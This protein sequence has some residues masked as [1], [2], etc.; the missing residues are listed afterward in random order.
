MCT[1][2]KDSFGNASSAYGLGREARLALEGARAKVATCI[3]ARADEIVFTSGGT[4]SDNLAIRGVAR[5]LAGHGNHIVTTAIEHHAVLHTCQSLE[6]E[7][8]EVTYVPVGSQGAVD[9][10]D[11][12][13][14]IRTDTILISIMHANNE[15][16]AIQPVAEVSAIAAGAGAVLHTDAVQ[17]LGK[18]PVDVGAMPADLISISGHKIYGPKG[19][20]ALYVK[21]DTQVLP[22]LTGG[23]HENG[24]RAGTEN[25]AGALALA[26]AMEIAVGYQEEEADRLAGLRERLERRVLESVDGVAVHGA[27]AARVSNTSNMSF[28]SVDGE[29]IVTRLDLAGICAATGSACTTDS[30]EPSHVL[31]AMGVEPRV[32]QGAVRFSLGRETTEEE[33]DYTVGALAE[34]V[35]Q[36]R[37]ISN[38]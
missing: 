22:C 14:A 31:L 38:L 10:G 37:S 17:A 33:I 3:G 29:A 18:T 2:L 19:T 30:P 24:L 8:F 11:V 34:A 28:L 16:G 23:H 35:G 27:G 7:G 4:E 21:R 1:C 20:G 9:P 25:V 6:G 36:L 32:A 12:L 13:R 5:G 26:E 15:T